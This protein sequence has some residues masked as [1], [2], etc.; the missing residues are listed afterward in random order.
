MT[1]NTTS[2]KTL[3]GTRVFKGKRIPHNIG[4]INKFI[5]YPDKNCI[6]GFHTKQSDFLLLIRRKGRFVS[7]KG[8][9]LYEDYAFVCKE[10]G[11][12]GKAAYNLLDLHPE[13]GVIWLGLPVITKDGQKVGVV[14]D[15]A[16]VHQSGEVLSIQ[17]AQGTVGRLLQGTRT[18]PIEMIQGYSKQGG[19]AIAPVDERAETDSIA[20]QAAIIVSN[21]AL[22]VGIDSDRTLPSKAGKTAVAIAKNAGVDT[23]VVSEKAKS[24]VE[25]AGVVASA[26]AT[27]TKSQLKKTRGMFSAFKDAYNEA[28]HGD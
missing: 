15:V 14:S 26:G 3:K 20:P 2:I 5:F 23:A 19:T 13:D 10:K 6:A 27:A 24:A 28:R 7:M 9:Y 22:S 11:S 4:K 17:S 8:Y 25:T 12:S 21:E 1:V 18:I 16:F